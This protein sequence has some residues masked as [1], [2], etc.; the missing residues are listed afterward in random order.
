[1]VIWYIIAAIFLAIGAV[2]LIWGAYN[3]YCGIRYKDPY[4]DFLRGVRNLSFAAF[5]AAMLW[6][7]GFPWDGAWFEWIKMFVAEHAVILGIIARVLLLTIGIPLLF[8][9]FALIK[10]LFIDTRKKDKMSSED[11]IRY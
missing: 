8:I 7:I 11:D 1:M 4:G 5:L 10:W 3:L 6:A 2:M 9:C